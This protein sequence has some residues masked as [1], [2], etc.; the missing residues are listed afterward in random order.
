MRQ[1][2][3]LLVIFFLSCGNN[4][5]LEKFDKEKWKKGTQI[6]RGNMSTNLVESNILIGKTKS[7][8][9]DLLGEPKDS[10]N[11]NFHYLVDFGYMIPFDLNIWFDKN[12]LR[13]HK[14]DLSD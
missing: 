5:K 4:H 11:T 9:L 7:E 10:T 3:L 1:I 6:E 14:T 2:L 8:V 13:V 12:S